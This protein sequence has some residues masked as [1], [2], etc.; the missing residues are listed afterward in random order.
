MRKRDRLTRVAGILGLL[1]ATM[2]PAAAQPKVSEP[3]GWSQ[4]KCDRYRAD[5]RDALRRFGTNALSASFIAAHDECLALGCPTPG[6]VCPRSPQELAL[7]NILT[8]RAM[9]AGMASTFL[10]F[11]CQR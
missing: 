6:H 8:V 10:P 11:R 7:A 4:I 1:L 3:S 2:L 5:W 9:N